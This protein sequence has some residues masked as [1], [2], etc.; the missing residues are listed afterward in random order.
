[1]VQ[2]RSHNIS[3]GS[4]WPVPSYCNIQNQCPDSKECDKGDYG[5]AHIH[6]TIYIPE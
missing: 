5:T 1:M 2:F 4:Y 3:M 6:N